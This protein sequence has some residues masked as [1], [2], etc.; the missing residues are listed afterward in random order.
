MWAIG[1]LWVVAIFTRIQD[2]VPASC[3]LA[4]DSASIDFG[5]AVQRSVVATFALSHNAVAACGDAAVVIA[6]ICIGIVL[7]VA[8]FKPLDDTIAAV[9]CGRIRAVRWT[10]A[11]TCWIERVTKF[12]C[13]GNTVSARRP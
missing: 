12:R 2:A 10:R 4:V 11:G 13:I 5:V 8:F 6:S 7:V 9:C 1:V 3:G